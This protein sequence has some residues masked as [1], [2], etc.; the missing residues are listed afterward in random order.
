MFVGRSPGSCRGTDM[1]ALSCTG[2]QSLHYKMFAICHPSQ[3]HIPMPHL[4]EL[5]LWKRRLERVAGVQWIQ[6]KQH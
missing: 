1:M 2:P 4:Q 3:P 5:M 6:E